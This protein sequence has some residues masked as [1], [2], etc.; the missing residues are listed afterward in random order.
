MNY[1]IFI[2]KETI[3][4]RFS[5]GIHLLNRLEEI[6]TE[7]DK[8][9]FGESHNYPF[10]FGFKRCLK[11]FLNPNQKINVREVV[12]NSEWIEYS[13]FITDDYLLDCVKYVIG[14]EAY[15][16]NK[17]KTS[18]NEEDMCYELYVEKIIKT[19]VVKLEDSILEKINKHNE[20]CE[21]YYEVAKMLNSKLKEVHEYNYKLKWFEFYKRKTFNTLDY[22][23]DRDLIEEEVQVIFKK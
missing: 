8:I 13:T 6:P 22:K 20:D 16:I 17:G 5:N 15:S 2:I 12:D 4:E 23:F 21:I 11:C 7:Y 3:S 9:R 14:D 19:E 10:G 1:K 18:Y